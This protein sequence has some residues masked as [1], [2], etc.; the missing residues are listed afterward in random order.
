M[1]WNY[2]RAEP[3]TPTH[4][5]PEPLIG[6]GHLVP[7]SPFPQLTSPSQ[8]QDDRGS[9]CLTVQSE[10]LHF[11]LPMSPPNRLWAHGY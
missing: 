2:A 9:G 3:I 6:P 8:L 10:T 5:H 1:L 7:L 4:L 11:P